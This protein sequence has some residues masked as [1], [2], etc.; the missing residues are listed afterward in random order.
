MNKK[1]DGLF[2]STFEDGSGDDGNGNDMQQ[3]VDEQHREGARKPASATKQQ[4]QQKP[5][6]RGRKSGGVDEDD[7]EAMHGG[8]DSDASAG[9]KKQ[10]GARKKRDRPL[11]TGRENSLGDSEDKL[12]RPKKATKSVAATTV[13]AVGRPRVHIDSNPLTK[14]QKNSVLKMIAKVVSS[15]PMAIYLMNPVNLADYPDYGRIV[16][17]P[18]CLS[19]VQARLNADGYACLN[20][21]VADVD[22]V[23]AN[24]RLYNAEGS[25]IYACADECEEEFCNIWVSKTSPLSSQAV[26]LVY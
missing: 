9:A 17:H 4:L 16:P 13:T 8:S 11:S 3:H 15:I 19:Q 6:K 21:V 14:Q 22:R 7:V 26:S 1:F 25:D 24:C 18:L 23:W 12:G 5:K 10:Q 2:S 20:D